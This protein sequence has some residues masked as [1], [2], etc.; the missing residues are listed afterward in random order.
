MTTTD[1]AGAAPGWL[2][3]AAA[4]GRGSL[5]FAAACQ[6]LQTVFT[7]GQWTALAWLAADLLTRGAHP[8]WPQMGLLFA[9][10][11]LAATA[12]WG[13]ARLQA[14]GH[15]Q[16][17]SAI[18]RQLVAMLLATTG[19]AVEP[20]PAGAALATVELA[21]DVADYHAQAGPQHRSAPAAM[22]VIF[23]VTAVVQWPAAIL[24]L[25][26][27]LIVVPN[28]RLAGVFAKEGA[29][30]RA[31]ATTRMAAVVLDSFRGIRTLQGL[32]ATQRR[33][34]QLSQA[35]DR[36]NAAMMAT[37]RRAFLSGAIMDL[38][39]TFSIA[40][41]ATY[42]G[43]SLLGY[44]RIDAA[45]RVTLFNGL[46]ALLLCP[47]YFAPLRAVAAAYHARERAVAAVPRITALLTG[48]PSVREPCSGSPV[49]GPVTVLVEAAGVCFPGS[50]E[51]VIRDV[52][53]TIRPGQWV[54][55]TGASGA[56]KTTLLSLIAGARAP[57]TG[58]VRWLTATGMVLP[59]LGSCA[60]IGQQTVILPGSI[61]DNIRLGRPDATRT[62]VERAAATAGLSDVVAR[63]ADGLDTK[64]G[65]G[66]WGLST[67]E[68]RRIAIARAF[69]RDAG[70]WVLD[71]PTSHLD[72][73]AEADVI[74]ALRV[75]A[76][77]RTII[78]VTHSAPLAR[79]AD[80]VLVVSAGTVR[81]AQQVAA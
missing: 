41:N 81:P 52:D 23:L 66:G 67:G 15:R 61:A 51:P 80:T 78:V 69:L 36:L 74:D 53:V 28:L 4:P 63:L 68:A 54:A 22:A 50:S 59:R 18:R 79:A 2:D 26:A 5:R 56:G 8:R 72:P 16:I 75:A 35:A 73:D 29:D 71:E 25:L 11:L 76:R 20:D 46:V 48:T 45:P 19:R 42:I 37:V 30:D 55:V 1:P 21:D 24:L 6:V 43:L 17:G 77:G 47:M 32:G 12:D 3:A 38:V 49:L 13:A 39:I 64:L 40:V 58:T 65:E 10:G 57:S 7:V 44:V 60:W 27:S 33:R 31:T 14:A 70:L 34:T 62:E 9:G